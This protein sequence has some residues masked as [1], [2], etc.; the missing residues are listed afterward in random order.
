MNRLTLPVGDKFWDKHHPGDHWNCKCSLEQ[1]D[2]PANPDVLSHIPDVKPQKGLAANPGKT[3]EMFDRS[4]PYYEQKCSS[5][6][7]NKNK[8]FKNALTPS[9]NCNKCPL[10]NDCKENLIKED[11]ELERFKAERWNE[12]LKYKSDEDN[13]HDVIFDEKSGGFKATHNSH[14]LDKK[15][16]WYEEKVRD[17]GFKEGHKV[18]LER[19][20]HSI[21]K[22]KNTEGTWDDMV[23]EIAA[24]ETALPSNVRNALK[25]CA[26]K[27]GTEVAVIFF[28]KAKFSKQDFYQGYSMFKGLEGTSQY[29]RFKK[30]YCI[31]NDGIVLIKK[32]E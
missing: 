10:M 25:H 30:I 26:E 21:H 13:Y 2:D 31:D 1:T 8:S 4:H 20:I 11:L 17:I 16:G 14:N 18:I 6:W 19:E 28:P 3:G 23:L 27:P 22:L 15:K 32:P 9:G 7:V 5:C 24:A 29:K 12:Y